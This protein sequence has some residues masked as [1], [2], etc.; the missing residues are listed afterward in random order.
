M[1]IRLNES[2]KAKLD[3]LGLPVLQPELFVPLSV[4]DETDSCW[5]FRLKE[6]GH[7][8]AVPKDLCKVLRS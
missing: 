1:K 2:D 3:V 6:N 5:W 8:F 4:T 7:E